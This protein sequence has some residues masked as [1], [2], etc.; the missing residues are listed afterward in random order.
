MTVINEYMFIEKGKLNFHFDGFCYE[1]DF[2]LTHNGEVVP[3]DEAEVLE[4]DEGNYSFSYDYGNE[5]IFSFDFTVNS[6][7]IHIFNCFIDPEKS[8]EWG[9]DVPF[10]G[11]TYMK[12]LI[13]KE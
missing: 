3:L 5:L 7:K 12:E 2:E 1:D 9:R 13:C 8:D 6:D 10:T 4:L 11:V